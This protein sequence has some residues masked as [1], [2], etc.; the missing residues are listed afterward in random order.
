MI[1]NNQAFMRLLEA[2]LN[3][4]WFPKFHIKSCHAIP[5]V[6]VCMYI[7]IQNMY[8]IA[9]YH[10]VAFVLYNIIYLVLY[11]IKLYPHYLSNVVQYE[12][13]LSYWFCWHG[14]LSR[15]VMCHHFRWGHPLQQPT[16]LMEIITAQMDLGRSCDKNKQK[17]F[18]EVSKCWWKPV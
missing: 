8:R 16:L 4:C 2:G 14:F 18:L 17:L 5:Q 1:A 9:S 13:S 10:V 12:I 11:H 15:H 3:T 7:Y 6:C